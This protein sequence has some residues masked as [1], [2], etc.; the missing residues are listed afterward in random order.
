MVKPHNSW[1]KAC[2]R[3]FRATKPKYFF[4]HQIFFIFP[5][6]FWITWNAH[7]SWIR[8][9]W[10]LLRSILELSICDVCE[11]KKCFLNNRHQRSLFCPLFLIQ[12]TAIILAY[13]YPNFNLQERPWRFPTVIL[14]IYFHMVW[15]VCFVI[16]SFSG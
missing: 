1:V 7:T 13:N 9:C 5:R 3:I 15:K 2:I 16:F 4:N 11:Q 12:F 6:N 14:L 10:R 8:A